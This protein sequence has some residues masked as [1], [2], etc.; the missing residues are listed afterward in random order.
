M[1]DWEIYK[2]EELAVKIGMGPFGSNIKVSTF[3]NEGIPIISGEH[4]RETRLRDGN[5]N[6]ITQEHADRLYSSNVFRGDVIFTHAGNIGQ[7]S[8]IP[9][10]SSYERYII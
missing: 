4:L 2:L 7:V 3:V 1:A 6:F 10:N 5:Y 9:Y 8:Y